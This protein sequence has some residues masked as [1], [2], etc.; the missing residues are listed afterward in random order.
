MWYSSFSVEISNP[1]ANRVCT[2]QIDSAEI[3]RK[4]GRL[5]CAKCARRQQQ[6]YGGKNPNSVANKTNGHREFQALND[7]FDPNFAVFAEPHQ[8][9]RRQISRRQSD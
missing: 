8:K 2:L 3:G 1:A 7:L 9:S 6:R 4:S 5:K